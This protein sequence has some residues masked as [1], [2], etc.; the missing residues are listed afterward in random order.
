M[1]MTLNEAYASISQQ[2]KEIEDLLQKNMPIPGDPLNKDDKS[3]DP[4][5]MPVSPDAAAPGSEGMPPEGA[6]A[7]TSPDAAAPEGS[8]GAPE[9]GSDSMDVESIAKELEGMPNEDI[10]T[11][12]EILTNALQTRSGGAPEGSAPAAEQSLTTPSES[13]AP[14]IDEEKEG[15]KQ[16]MAGLQK[17]ITALKSENESLKKSMKFPAPKKVPTKNVEVLE[18]SEKQP[19]ALSKQEVIDHLY[20]LQKSGNSNID[21]DLMWYVTRSKTPEELKTATE[22]CKIKGIKF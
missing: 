13:A 3:P 11:L 7:A 18:K 1:V 15:M 9:A 20:R 12:I 4:A 2:V 6:E 14:A 17:S 10:Q 8:E 5:S 22:M 19:E 16:Q 21:T